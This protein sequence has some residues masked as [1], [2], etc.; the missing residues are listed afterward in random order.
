ML[1]ARIIHNNKEYLSFCPALKYG[2]I[3]EKSF[4]DSFQKGVPQ[5]LFDNSQGINPLAVFHITSFLLTFFLAQATC[6]PA[7]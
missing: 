4:Q 7:Y 5:E 6:S 3:F 1:L 2:A